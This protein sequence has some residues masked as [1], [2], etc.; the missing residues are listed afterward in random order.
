VAS[1]RGRP[2][3]SWVLDSVRAAGFNEVLVVTGA[4]PLDG[5]LPEDVRVL[6]NPAWADGQATSLALAVAAAEE[7]GHRALV[8]GL[9]DQPLVP[10]SA[11]RTVGAT[12]GDIVTASFDGDRRPPVK[13]ERSVWPLLP[14]GGDE[15]ARALMRSRPDLVCAVPCVGNPVDIDTLE[16]LVRWS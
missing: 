1:F 15:G 14:T 12:A 8:I 11:W 2:V 4:D 5:L 9:G 3:V 10:T 16:D 13:L 6:P 7:A